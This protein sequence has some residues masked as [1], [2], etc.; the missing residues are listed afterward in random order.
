MNECWKI[1]ENNFND[2]DSWGD[3][4][5]TSE[6]ETEVKPRSVLGL[7]SPNIC[8]PEDEQS[9]NNCMKRIIPYLW[10]YMVILNYCR[11]FCGVKFSNWKLQ[12]KTVY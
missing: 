5:R 4:S 12:N 1:M 3:T 2:I 10:I 8:Q 11:V 6:V 7:K 9:P